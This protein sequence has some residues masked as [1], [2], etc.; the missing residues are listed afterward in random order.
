V[1]ELG[2]GREMHWLSKFV[3][4]QKN[5]AGSP[6]DRTT[7][8]LVI[9]VMVGLFLVIMALVLCFLVTLFILYLIGLFF[10]RYFT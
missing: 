1:T 9:R 4:D 7:V 10:S 5:T 2:E 8:S 3:P 6:A